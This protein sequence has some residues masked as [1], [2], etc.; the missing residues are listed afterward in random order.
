MKR[1]III[2]WSG[3]GK[4]TFAQRLGKK[5]NIEV[6]H[7]DKIYHLPGWQQMDSDKFR[8]IVSDLVKKEE[9]IIDGHYGK[10]MDLRIEG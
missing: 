5:L 2:G 7:L 9:W 8:E 4:S 1:I 3:S 10:T 6:I